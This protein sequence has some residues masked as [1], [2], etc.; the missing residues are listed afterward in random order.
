MLGAVAAWL[1]VYA[2]FAIA[3]ARLRGTN[4]AYLRAGGNLANQVLFKTAL[5]MLAPILAVA[6]HIN[7]GFVPLVFVPLYAVQRM[8]TLSSQR[9]RQSRLDPLT[10][11]ANRT[12]LKLAFA[13]LTGPTRDPGE[14]VTLLL[15]D[16]DE[17][18]HVNDALGHEVGDQLLVAV[19]DRLARLPV[20]ERHH[21]SPR[22]RRVRVHHCHRNPAEAED[23][24]RAVVSALD[25]AGVPGRPARRRDRVGRHRDHASR[26]A[27]TSPP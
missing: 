16:L 14:Q 17:F 26:D 15:A 5:V 27:R 3:V 12:G 7:I 24:A 2:G 22:R 13:A 18:K 11:L 4:F 23:L 6:A 20:H 21:R 25:R 8:A 19:A 1:L 10:G 9:D